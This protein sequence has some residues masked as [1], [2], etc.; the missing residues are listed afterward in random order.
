[1][2]RRRTAELVHR[3]LTHIPD[4]ALMMPYRHDASLS[5][6][7]RPRTPNSAWLLS[8]LSRPPRVRPLNSTEGSVAQVQSH[9]YGRLA[10][11]GGPML[12]WN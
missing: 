6:R 8:A 4:Q 10:P 9:F 5:L 3:A 2:G 1:M 11:A 7:A 12:R